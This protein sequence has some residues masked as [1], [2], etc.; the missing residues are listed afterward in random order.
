M[1]FLIP[2]MV[3]GHFMLSGA[4]PAAAGQPPAALDSGAPVRMAGNDDATSDRDTYTQK[5][6]DDMQ[7]WQRKL[8]EYSETAEA[9]GSEAGKAAENEL[10][11]AWTKAEAASR[12]LET[13]SADGWESARTSY[14]KAS[15]DLADAWHKVRPDEK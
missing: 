2:T 3:V 12:Q 5:A 6:R 10:H 4:A 8:H 14:D 13:A 1:G 15:H 11:A 9:K 7:E